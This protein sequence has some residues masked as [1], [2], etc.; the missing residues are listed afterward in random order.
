M[1]NEREGRAV[2]RDRLRGCVWGERMATVPFGM[3]VGAGG[4][5]DP[6]LQG[7][8]DCAYPSVAVT[9]WGRVAGTCSSSS[10]PR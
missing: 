9:P 7:G 6:W 2:P 8:G 3:Y 4:V 1:G 10:F 5:K